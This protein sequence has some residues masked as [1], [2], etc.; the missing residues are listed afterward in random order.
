MDIE[1][2]RNSNLVQFIIGRKLGAPLINL[3]LIGI[4]QSAETF[5]VMISPDMKNIISFG[6]VGLFLM[7]VYG[8]I[9]YDRLLVLNNQVQNQ[10]TN[11]TVVAAHPT[12]N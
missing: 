8:D 6:L 12:S 2:F 9:Q 11:T 7:V 1:S 3:G 4:V 5:G 10:V